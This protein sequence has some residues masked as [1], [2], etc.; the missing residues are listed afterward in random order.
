MKRNSFKKPLILFIIALAICA[1]VFLPLPYYIEKPGSTIDLKEL[2]TVNDKKDQEDGSFSL[3]SVGVQQ[4]SVVTALKAQ[5]SPFEDLVSEEELLG[6]AS[7][8]EYDQMQNYYMESSQNTAIQQ[9]LKLADRPYDFEYKGVYVMNVMKNSSFKGEVAVG[10]TV[11]KVDGKSFENNQDFMDYVQQKS[12]GDT[13][14]VTYEHDDD[15]KEASG[16]LIKLPSNQKAGIGITLVDHTDITTE[17]E[18]DFDVDNIGGPSAGLMFTLEIY[19]QLTEQNLRQ[20]KNIA[21]TGTIDN[22]GKIGRIGG[23]DK[24]V[25]SA[26]EAG[27]QIFFAPNDTLTKKEKKE[28]PDVKSN[29]QEAQT[30][31]DELDTDMKIV[32]VKTLQDAIDY[33]E[34]L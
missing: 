26:D 14:K 34:P 20:N 33:L 6:G 8:E 10:D 31:A 5:I 21:G 24:K 18:V 1:S 22:K 4:A 12:V 30:A 29:Y 2:I 27:A 3:T 7:D 11:T 32:P 15:T 16:K 17:D 23:I 9:A 19:E 28:N 25:A 13:V